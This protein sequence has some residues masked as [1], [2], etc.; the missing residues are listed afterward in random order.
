GFEKVQLS[1]FDTN[2]ALVAVDTQETDV[3]GFVKT[4][5]SSLSQGVYFLTVTTINSLTHYKVIKK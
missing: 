3:N 4:N 5:I 1:I 2:G